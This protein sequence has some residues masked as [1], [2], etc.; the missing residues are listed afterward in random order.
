MRN[1]RGTVLW[2][3]CGGSE[4]GVAAGGGRRTASVTQS[5]RR[6]ADGAERRA[7]TRDLYQTNAAARPPPTDR[8]ER[9]GMEL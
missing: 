6:R 3:T 5:V 8:Q 4:A 7:R 2:S 1:V 9:S